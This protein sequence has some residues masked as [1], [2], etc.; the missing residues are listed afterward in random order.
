MRSLPN[1]FEAAP[2]YED[3]NVAIDHNQILMDLMDRIAQRHNLAVLLHEKPFA[4]VNGSGKHCNWALSTDKGE[5]LLN[6]GKTPQSNLQSSCSLSPRSKRSTNIRNSSALRSPQLTM[7]I[8]LVRMKLLRRSSPFSL[9][10][11]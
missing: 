7:T 10:N 4:N 5:N 3:V 9:A 2:I 6:P 1:Q 11:C 8:V